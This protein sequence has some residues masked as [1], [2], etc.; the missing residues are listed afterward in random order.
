MDIT[1]FS[2]IFIYFSMSMKS[3]ALYNEVVLIEIYQTIT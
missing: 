3:V 2:E 1:I